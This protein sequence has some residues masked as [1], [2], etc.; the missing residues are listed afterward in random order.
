MT[1]NASVTQA[2]ESFP[3]SLDHHLAFLAVGVGGNYTAPFP[4]LGA[5]NRKVLKDTG[6]VPCGQK[7]ARLWAAAT[8]FSFVFLFFWPG[9][10]GAGLHTT[11]KG[12]LGT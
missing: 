9:G 8:C 2:E 4:T 7:E 12:Y 1:L 10:G 6:L 3:F 11:V 5:S